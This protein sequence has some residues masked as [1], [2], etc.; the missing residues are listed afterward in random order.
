VSLEGKRQRTGLP[1]ISPLPMEFE[2]AA[3]FEVDSRIKA[4]QRPVRFCALGFCEA[5]V[6]GAQREGFVATYPFASGA[7]PGSG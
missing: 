4:G 3:G 1:L 5:M 7:P 2:K 6:H